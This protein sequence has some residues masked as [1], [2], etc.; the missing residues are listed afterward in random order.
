MRIYWKRKQ[1]NY[2]QNSY[3][4]EKC[5]HHYIF[6]TNRNVASNKMPTVDADFEAPNAIKPLREVISVPEM[7]LERAFRKGHNIDLPKTTTLSIGDESAQCKVKS[8]AR[9]A[10]HALAIFE[11]SCSSAHHRIL[12]NVSSF[13]LSENNKKTHEKLDWAMC[14]QMTFSR[15]NSGA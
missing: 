6:W 9:T 8:A 10:T 14:I 7:F 2:K 1:F 15:I 11:S 5:V 12:H 4:L 13:E 3:S